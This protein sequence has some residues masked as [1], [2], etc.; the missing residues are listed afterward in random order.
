MLNLFNSRFPGIII[1]LLTYVLS[2]IRPQEEV[3]GAENLSNF[4]EMDTK[5]QED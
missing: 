1:G 3:E 4:T 2:K 5:A